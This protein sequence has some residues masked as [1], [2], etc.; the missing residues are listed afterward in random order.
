MANDVI[1]QL[2]ARNEALT[3]AIARYGSLN[4][5]TLQTLST[6]QVKITKL[7]QQLTESA[8]R[9][10]ENDKQLTELV[11]KRKVLS[12]NQANF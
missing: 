11:G 8:L 9:R 12:D 3:Q 7:T 4:A 10:E 1:T 6:E 5:S 2:Q